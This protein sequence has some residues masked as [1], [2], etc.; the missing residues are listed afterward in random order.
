MDRPSQHD[1]QRS[2]Q[3][4][5]LRAHQV[6]RERVL[7][8]LT[9]RI[10]DEHLVHD[11]VQETFLRYWKELI[12]GSRIEHPDRWLVRVAINLSEDW[13]RSFQCRQVSVGLGGNLLASLSDDWHFPAVDPVPLPPLGTA[14]LDLL[15]PNDRLI[16]TLRFMLGLETQTIGVLMGIGPDA[17]RMRLA[18]AIKKANSLLFKG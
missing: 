3:G 2:L 11:L 12:T 6:S 14:R 13:R 15:R 5:F 17:A 9:N 1:C 18:R 8:V 10:N 7:K 4:D 16:I